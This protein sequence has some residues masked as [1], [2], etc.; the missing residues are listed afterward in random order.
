[1]TAIEDAHARAAER[2]RWKPVRAAWAAI[3]AT[4]WNDCIEP[5]RDQGQNQGVAKSPR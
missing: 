3:H 5:G 2:S 4:A 1:M